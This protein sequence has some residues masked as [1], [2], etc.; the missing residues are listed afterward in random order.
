MGVLNAA[1]RLLA[2]R[3]AC[4]V[5]CTRCGG[6]CT[7]HRAYPPRSNSAATCA[8]FPGQIAAPVIVTDKITYD[9]L[10]VSQLVEYAYTAHHAPFSAWH[11]GQKEAYVWVC[12]CARVCFT[13]P[14]PYWGRSRCVWRGLAVLSS[15]NP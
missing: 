6:G 13:A 1:R 12:A 9:D 15:P 7:T 11:G 14:A 5:I 3:A 10:P 4:C 2:P 8:L